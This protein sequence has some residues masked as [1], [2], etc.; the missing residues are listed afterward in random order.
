VA[1]RP[2]AESPAAGSIA[3]LPL[4]VK[5]CRNC[6]HARLH[7]I[8][9]P[10]VPEFEKEVRVCAAD[11]PCWPSVVTSEAFFTNAKKWK[12]RAAHCPAYRRKLGAR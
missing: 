5:S 8:R 7:V 2:V 3:V 1:T 6:A 4:P 10:D 9:F 11:S 12:E